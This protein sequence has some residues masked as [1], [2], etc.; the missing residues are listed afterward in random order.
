[1]I[2]PTEAGALLGVSAVR[3][4]QLIGAGRIPH[5][6]VGRF[7]MIE[8]KAVRAFRRLEPGRPRKAKGK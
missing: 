6:R 2:T 1:M 4:R 7:Y 8:M 3:V 5:V